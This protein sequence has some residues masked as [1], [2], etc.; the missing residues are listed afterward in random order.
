MNIRIVEECWGI[1]R[2]TGKQ[3]SAKTDDKVFTPIVGTAIDMP[4]GRRSFI[5]DDVG[6]IGVTV[7]VHYENNPSAN[8]TWVIAKGESVNYRPMSMDGGYK[9]T[10]TYENES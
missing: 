8:K 6:D 10:I 2:R 3:S 1:N 5:V 9:Y 4:I 7:T